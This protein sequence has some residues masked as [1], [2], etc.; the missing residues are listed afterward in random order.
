M[1]GDYLIFDAQSTRNANKIFKELDKKWLIKKK[2]LVTI[3]GISGTRKSETAYKLAEILINNGKQ[4]HVISGDDYYKI[5]WDERPDDRK[6]TDCINV[7]SNEW[8]WKRIWWTLETFRNPLYNT[9]QFF[10]MSKFTTNIMQCF[11]EKKECDFL[12]L[13][14]LYA[15]DLRIDADVRIHIGNTNPES[16]FK[17]RN[18]RKK[19][20]EN[21]ILRQKVV[22]I[23]CKHVEQL[24]KNADLVI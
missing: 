4:S 1:F 3:G 6:K 24:K 11:L 15:C 16:T 12:I 2:V 7:G 23:E 5:P 21:S 9:I 10:Q 18:K 22:E 17:F 20:N 19:E 13:E 8:D 14:G